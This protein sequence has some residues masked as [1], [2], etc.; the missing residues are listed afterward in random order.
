MSMIERVLYWIGIVV[1]IIALVGIKGNISKLE[2]QV[3]QATAQV[4]E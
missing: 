4:E 1:L 3:S 2:Q